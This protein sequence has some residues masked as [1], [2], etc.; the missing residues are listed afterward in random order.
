MPNLVDPVVA[1]TV[2]LDMRANPDRVMR[3]VVV[4]TVLLLA[5]LALK[6][7]ARRGHGVW[8][9]QRLDPAVQTLRIWVMAAPAV[10][11]YTAVWTVTTVLQQGAPEQLTDLLSRWH[12]TNI[13]GLASEP[14]R[15]LFS[16]AF[17]VADN[18]YGFVGY[19]VVYV[20]IAARLEH[21]VGAVRFLLVAAMAH[22]LA[23][24][25]IV[26]VEDWA[27]RAGQA[28]AAL[29]FTIDVGVSYVM[30]G[31]VGAYL[32]LVGR[33]WLPWL[34]LSLAVGVGLPMIISG[35]IWDLGHL[36]ATL[37]GL[38]GGWVATR[39]PLREPLNW[40]HL[41]ASAT[42]RALPT[43]PAQPRAWPS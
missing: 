38:L 43:F 16:S 33:K 7:L 12:S 10:F 23:S 36:L 41:Q 37:F 8:L 26:L 25:V 20:M 6:A 31:T 28:P 34:A 22:V 3:M 5:W 40:R 32:W 15:V 4:M 1:D 24:L 42:P 29:K 19:V 9:F 11:T 18:G 30:V 17:V 35:T 13:V 27:I 21:R 39:F 2:A 14:L